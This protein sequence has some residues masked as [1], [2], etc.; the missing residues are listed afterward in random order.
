MDLLSLIKLKVSDF[1]A[2]KIRLIDEFDYSNI[3]W[4]VRQELGS[5]VSEEYLDEG[6]ENLKKYYV[7]ALLDPL[8]EHAVSARVD[9]FWHVHILFTRDY[10]SFCSSVFNQFIHHEPLNEADELEVQR[11][12]GLYAY[13]QDIYTEM[14][15]NHDIVWWPPI[16]SEDFKCICRHG[17]INDALTK[18]HALFKLV[19]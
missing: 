10:I 6:I 2:E 4:K 16:A 1:H 13:T 8:N 14:F 17:R 11:I 19:A 3:R 12:I 9:P 15:I 5:F 7:V 18:T